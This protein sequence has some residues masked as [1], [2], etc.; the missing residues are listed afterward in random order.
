MLAT[1]LLPLATVAIDTAVETSTPLVATAYAS[2]GGSGSKH[3]GGSGKGGNKGSKG[4]KGGKG[5]KKS[6]KGDKNAS[7][8][9]SKPA[10]D[11]GDASTDPGGNIMDKPA[12]DL[13]SQAAKDLVDPDGDDNAVKAN[14][15]ASSQKGK[16]SSDKDSRKASIY[17]IPL[18]N[19]DDYN[20]G[21]AWSFMSSDNQAFWSE[22]VQGNASFNVSVDN[23]SRKSMAHYPS[24]FGRNAYWAMENAAH[25][26]FVMDQLGLDKSFSQGFNGQKHDLLTSLGA[27]LME[28]CYGS[29]QLVDKAFSYVLNMLNDY[30]PFNIFVKHHLNSDQEHFGPLNRLIFHLY[31]SSKNFGQVM[32]VLIFGIGI[33][34]AAMGI[35]VGQ[36]SNISQARGMFNA[37]VDMFK[38]AFISLCLPLVLATCYSEVLALTT[39]LFNNAGYAPGNYAV[40]STMTSFEDFVTHGR[41]NFSSSFLRNNGIPNQKGAITDSRVTN[42]YLNHRSTLSINADFNRSGA[43]SLAQATSGSDYN[44]TKQILNADMGKADGQSTAIEMLKDYVSNRT[45]DASD[46]VSQVMPGIPS[47]GKD[48]DDKADKNKNKASD[49]SD[50]TDL[51]SRYYSANGCLHSTPT[52]IVMGSSG[53]QVSNSVQGNSSHSSADDLARRPGGLSTIGMY[54]YLRSVTNGS[55][56]DESSPNK[57]NN[58]VSNP[59]HFAVNFV[60][61]GAVANCNVAFAVALMLVMAGIALGTLWFILKALFDALP[62][63]ISGVIQGALGSLAGGARAVGAFMGFFISIIVTGAFYQL[64]FRAIVGFTGSFESFFGTNNGTGAGDTLTSGAI[65]LLGFDGKAP[66]QVVGA[67]SLNAGSFAMVTLIEAGIMIY[68]LILF[69]R[70]RKS[71][72]ASLSAMVNSSFT[73]IMQS[74]GSISGKGSY[75]M[76]GAGMKEHAQRSGSSGIPSLINGGMKATRVAN[77]VTKA[78]TGGKAGLGTIAG[79]GAGGM[80][81]GMA[82]K[83]LSN[84]ATGKG[85]TSIANKNNSNKSLKHS[86]QANHHS[87]KNDSKSN[88]SP[89]SAE[90]ARQQAALQDLASRQG[91]PLDAMDTSPKGNSLKQDAEQAQAQGQDPMDSMDQNYSDQ[92]QM[93]KLASQ[94]GNAQDPLAQRTAGIQSLAHK[95]NGQQNNMQ[96]LS[97]Q[98]SPQDAL[99]QVLAASGIQDPML[100][101]RNGQGQMGQGA[102]AMQ[103]K[104]LAQGQMQNVRPQTNA[105]G[106]SM[107]GNAINNA[108]K[109]N[110]AHRMNDPM[111][112][113]A[114]SQYQR[115][116]DGKRQATYDGQEADQSQMDPME[117]VMY[118]NDGVMQ[119]QDQGDVM[120]GVQAGYDQNGQMQDPMVNTQQQPGQ[121]QNPMVNT[122]QQSGQMQDP[123]ANTLQQPSQTQNPMPNTLQ[124]PL[125]QKQ[126]QQI[127][128][129]VNKA[130]GTNISGDTLQ[131]LEPHA[132]QMLSAAEGLGNIMDGGSDGAT[133]ITATGN[134]QA[135][136]SQGGTSSTIQ[137]AP[138]INSQVAYG[139]GV[140]VLPGNVP[141]GMSVDPNY[142]SSGAGVI[143]GGLSNALGQVQNTSARV[144]QA[145]NAV[146]ANP[147]NTILQGRASQALQAQQ[148]AQVQAMRIYNQTPALQTMSSLVNSNTPSHISTGQVNQAVSDVYAKQQ[149]FKQAAMKFGQQAPQTQQAAQNYQQ[150]IHTARQVHIKSAIL[151]QPQYLHQAY[152]TVRKQQMSIMNGTFKL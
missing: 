122:Q 113:M 65:R 64:S 112:T 92:G 133:T 68:L 74:F 69:F 44:S 51:T 22:D 149:D 147:T 52:R 16:G 90:E 121:M 63:S 117:Q 9:E 101:G 124:Q 3:H 59:Q 48:K 89:K 10:S 40:Y 118:D 29:T 17:N 87:N 13:G 27:N 120:N 62:G 37:G 128:G 42:A 131:Q 115:T 57:R 24:E 86:S 56:V 66:D 38:R 88:S 151:Q 7:S 138:G 2:G 71:L 21:N 127:A 33:A 28:L 150:A 80:A 5:S 14:K 45:F 79:L 35:Q 34:L 110:D 76:Q 60:G 6:D 18:G 107:V 134:G 31:D 106:G 41:L 67:I 15:K 12:A 144:V 39:N 140:G 136:V 135:V 8:G 1:I 139:K 50:L 84:L 43:K 95:Q 97:Q 46:Y 93:Q 73:R 126:N 55:S 129:A 75:G 49:G 148:Q 125:S 105:N 109:M 81:A 119:A 78:L 132:G 54:N 102:R 96:N 130:L 98:Q 104:S 70:W 103:H 53:E 123:M 19:N 72:I 30:N 32:M 114:N 108:H 100:A 146:Q 143:H 137:Q 26:P 83:G 116:A 91:N 141:L 58:Q 36:Q 82:M 20:I 145:N 23:D 47:K 77:G 99:S 152:Q 4:S 111:N 85:N 61:T 11:H 142:T 94:Q 25:L